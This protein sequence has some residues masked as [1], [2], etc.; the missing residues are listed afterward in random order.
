MPDIGNYTET[1]GWVLAEAGKYFA[2]LLFSVLAIR[3]WRRWA[4][5]SGANQSGNLFLACAFTLVAAAIGYFSM[6]QSLGKLYSYY[7]MSAFHAGR[8]PQALS[9]FETSSHYWKS[10]DALGRQGVCLLLSGNADQGLPLIEQAKSL[11][12]GRNVPFEAFYEGLYFFT[13]GQPGNSVPLLETASADED[14]RWSVVK[15]FAVMALDEN[16]VADAAGQMKPY[17]EAEVT[18]FDQAYIIASLKLAEGKKAEARALLEKFS[19]PNLSP[20]WQTRFEKLRR[21][22]R[23]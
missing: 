1:T 6:R 17:R 9:L 18:E 23:D 8:L 15:L 3:L 2:L 14:Y 11:R 5:S 4:G 16:R 20:M 22:L 10:A 12:Q 13:R 21:Q 7:G 19:G